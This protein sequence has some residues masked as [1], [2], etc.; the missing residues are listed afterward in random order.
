MPARPATGLRAF[1]QHPIES[2]RKISHWVE[3]QIDSSASVLR[4]KVSAEKA[5]ELDKLHLALRTHPSRVKDAFKHDAG[6]VF[7]SLS[8]LKS[9]EESRLFNVMYSLK[10]YAH[11][12]KNGI[13]YGGA[14]NFGGRAEGLLN[15]LRARLTAAGKGEQLARVEAATEDFA[16]RVDDVGLKS[17]DGMVDP[18]VFRGWQKRNRYYMF[19]RTADHPAIPD[20]ENLPEMDEIFTRFLKRRKGFSGMPVLDPIELFSEYH[21]K[22]LLAQDKRRI[23]GDAVKKLGTV[24]GNSADLERG[25]AADAGAVRYEP[26]A[27]YNL[28]DHISLPREV[29]GIFKGGDS[30]TSGIFYQAVQDFSSFFH[31]G[32]L[33]LNPR[34]YAASW[35]RDMF[36]TALRSRGYLTP[37]DKALG[38]G[39]NTIVKKAGLGRLAEEAPDLEP[40][41]NPALW[42]RALKATLRENWGKGDV[43][44]DQLRGTGAIQMPDVKTLAKEAMPSQLLSRGEKLAK[45]YVAPRLMKTMDDFWRVGQ[46][47]RAVDDSARGFSGMG[48]MAKLGEDGAQVAFKDF[49]KHLLNVRGTNIDFEMKSDFLRRL[50]A[51][52]PFLSAMIQSPYQTWQFAKA[53]PFSMA[54]R[55]TGFMSAATAAYVAMKGRPD[56]PLDRFSDYDKDRYIFADTGLR[57]GNRPIFAPI[58]VVPEPIQPLWEALRRMIDID[59]AKDPDFK[60]GL[61]DRF[62]SETASSALGSYVNLGGPIV[63]SI[64]APMNHSLYKGGKSIVAE[65]QRFDPTEL[66]AAEGTQNVYRFISHVLNKVPG[67]M[68]PDQYKHLA[69]G[70]TG[71]LSELAADA[72]DPLFKDSVP[73]PYVNISGGKYPFPVGD[74]SVLKREKA[75][76]VEKLTTALGLTRRGNS[77]PDLDISRTTVGE[78]QNKERA[79]V[80]ELKH[81]Q[82]I[83]VLS[84][85]EAQQQEAQGKIADVLRRMGEELGPY[86]GIPNVKEILKNVTK[87]IL[88]ENN[89]PHGK[90][91][92]HT[93]DRQKGYLFRVLRNEHPEKP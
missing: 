42:F 34:F 21:Y 69:R 29:A 49:D 73:V 85:D 13:N 86:G 18:E 6:F 59:A 79:L 3:D 65:R 44:Y 78:V 75:P 77:D 52:S 56:D 2:V 11:Q 67:N 24:F 8:R 84:Q 74:S 58:G 15:E 37:L 80:A 14:S 25:L 9:A 33:D 54:L 82:S 4:S 64:E 90:V 5:P 50:D 39:Y 70:F 88:F 91:L 10:H 87:D 41:L 36:D 22:R 62:L 12:Y 57:R 23:I 53:Q 71:Q 19:A 63:A 26:P 40:L 32:A 93:P 61:R 20:G 7:D 27:A 66:Q 47:L 81:W 28:G 68:A 48:K 72:V 76:P 1:F 92:Q 45:V 38:E 30:M 35:R 17:V 16:S 43:L 83:I 60:K 89:V 46:A 55:T 31:K 51:M